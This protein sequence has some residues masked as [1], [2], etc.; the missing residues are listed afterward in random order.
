PLN[1]LGRVKFMFLNK[2]NVYLHD[3]PAPPHFAQAQRGPHP[4]RLPTPTVLQPRR[5]PDPAAD[6]ARGVSAPPG[7]TVESRRAAGRAGRGG[8]PHRAAAGTDADPLAVLECLG[9]RGRFD[10]VPP[11]YPRSG[12]TAPEGPAGAAT[13]HNYVAVRGF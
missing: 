13:P 10:S 6:R 1:A 11:R 7:S 5:H 3:T 4:G 9:R 2:Y 12:R 8:G